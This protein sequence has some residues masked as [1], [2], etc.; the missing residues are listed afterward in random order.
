MSLNAVRKK[1][2]SVVP[3]W[4]K[5]NSTVK[6]SKVKVSFDCVLF[7]F[8]KLDNIIIYTSQTGL[9]SS[10]VQKKHKMF[11]PKNEQRTK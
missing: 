10:S 7:S 11:K 5:N 9:E 2:I 1:E 6:C 4:Y 3:I 8:V